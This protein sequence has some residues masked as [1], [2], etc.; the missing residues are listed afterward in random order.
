MKE[1][2]LLFFGAEAPE[3]DLNNDVLEPTEVN[4]TLPPDFKY[5][6][7]LPVQSPEELQNASQQNVEQRQEP[8][9]QSLRAFG[10]D[11]ADV[12]HQQDIQDKEI[13]ARREQEGGTEFTST[14]ITGQILDEEAGSQPDLKGREDVASSDVST[15]ATLTQEQSTSSTDTTEKTKV[16]PEK[17]KEWAENIQ[18]KANSKECGNYNVTI[19]PQGN[20]TMQITLN[21]DATPAQQARFPRLQEVADQLQHGLAA[22]WTDEQTIVVTITGLEEHGYVGPEWEGLKTPPAPDDAFGAEEEQQPAQTPAAPVEAAA[23]APQDTTEEAPKMDEGEISSRAEQLIAEVR[24]LLELGDVTPAQYKLQENSDLAAQVSKLIDG[25]SDFIRDVFPVTIDG[26][27][28][29]DN[30]TGQWN[31][32]CENGEFKLGPVAE[33]G[34][35]TEELR[36]T[37]IP[38]SGA[39]EEATPSQSTP[40]AAEEKPA[41]LTVELKAQ[42]EILTNKESTTAERFGAA[43]RITVLALRIALQEANKTEKPEAASGKNPEEQSEE[44]K[45]NIEQITKGLTDMNARRAQIDTSL[46]ELKNKLPSEEDKSPGAEMQ[47]EAL[48]AQITALEGERS[49]LDTAIAKWEG[50]LA[51]LQ[52][53]ATPAES[54]ISPEQMEKIR[55]LLESNNRPALMPLFELMDR[56]SVD[57]STGLVCNDDDRNVIVQLASQLGV[58]I[59][60]TTDEGLL[61]TLDNIVQK[62][63]SA[64][65]EEQKQVDKIVAEVFGEEVPASTAKEKTT[66]PKKASEKT[67]KK[68]EG[69]T[70]KAAEPSEKTVE[71]KKPSFDQILDELLDPNSTDNHEWHTD[72]T[73]R[74]MKKTP[75]GHI[76]LRSQAGEVQAWGGEQTGWIDPSKIVGISLARASDNMRE[77]YNHAFNAYLEGGAYQSNDGDY[78]LQVSSGGEFSFIH[79]K[80]DTVQRYDWRNGRMTVDEKATEERMHQRFAQE[81]DSASPKQKEA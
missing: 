44:T 74:A 49:T 32:T 13:L 66:T 25:N 65:G 76:F 68:D 78:A 75:D 37:T 57:K 67:V 56:L 30:P 43:L 12:M 8:T 29:P 26:A 46:T 69:E 55:T 42:T 23:S 64:D 15:E 27:E 70:P 4:D 53:K 60:G 40:E 28:S 47:R 58:H 18:E 50:E 33:P 41:D 35:N 19:E 22:E 31:L 71:S 51:K 54:P 72:S 62:V 52:P 17:L 9:G 16:S 1:R 36:A 24:G 3:P 39:E 61:K 63:A 73:G 34:T 59:E 10:S 48:T 14:E 2:R 21:P 77:N 20:G 11:V 45:K 81:K 79:T 80:G 6:D 5:T 38:P 7:L